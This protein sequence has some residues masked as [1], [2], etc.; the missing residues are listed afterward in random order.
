[1]SMD[2]PS[3]LLQLYSIT[4]NDAEVYTDSYRWC[5]I[6]YNSGEFK[7]INKVDSIVIT[8][9]LFSNDKKFLLSVY[10]SLHDDENERINIYINGQKIN[11]F[12]LS[13]IFWGEKYD[14]YIDGLVSYEILTISRNEIRK[15]KVKEIRNKL[16]IEVEYI[17]KVFFEKILDNNN[18]MFT[19][20]AGKKENSLMWGLLFQIY[21]NQEYKCFDREYKVLDYI[22]SNL[23]ESFEVAIKTESGYAT[24]NKAYLEIFHAM[25]AGEAV[26]YMSVLELNNCFSNSVGAMKSKNIK[27]MHKILSSDKYDNILQD[28]DCIILD[29]NFIDAH[30]EKIIYLCDDVYL[31]KVIHSQDKVYMLRDIDTKTEKQLLVNIISKKNEFIVIPG[32]E[33]YKELV[34]KRKPNGFNDFSV[35]GIDGYIILPRISGDAETINN[36]IS[37]NKNLRTYFNT[38]ANKRLINYVVRNNINEKISVEDVIISYGKILEQVIET[39]NNSTVRC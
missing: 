6:N 12:L 25:R 13:D 9:K 11:T 17:W 39:Y 23:D 4:S 1:M 37:N 16:C 31:I 38:A 27:D 30:A 8:G 26:W 35:I 20:I 3:R 14:I 33:K 24:T 34:V 5:S 18:K 2:K 10:N 7:L 15:D 28:K 32:M 29:G 19:N 22:L 36:I 21:L